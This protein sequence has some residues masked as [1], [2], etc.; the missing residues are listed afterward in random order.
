MCFPTLCHWMCRNTHILINDWCHRIVCCHS[1]VWETSNIASYGLTHKWTAQILLRSCL[2]TRSIFNSAAQIKLKWNKKNKMKQQRA[3]K[4]LFS[5]R[6]IICFASVLLKIYQ[7]LF[8]FCFYWQEK[9]TEVNL[10][11]QQLCKGWSMTSMKV[12]NNMAANTQTLIIFLYR[13]AS[14]SYP[15]LYQGKL[16][17][18]TIFAF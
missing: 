3:R 6:Q 10:L 11:L 1:A 4:F 8:L 14:E 12:I 16:P 2:V 17:T 5:F 18:I 9:C 7:M 13:H 15:L